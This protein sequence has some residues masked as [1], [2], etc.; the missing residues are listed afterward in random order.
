MSGRF[1]V[2]QWRTFSHL[3]AE[4]LKAAGRADTVMSVTF[5]I[6]PLGQPR[7]PDDLRREIQGLFSSYHA[8][9]LDFIVENVQ[10]GIDALEER[11]GAGEKGKP[12]L[13]I[14]FD[15]EANKFTISD[16]GLGIPDEV[17]KKLGAPSNSD[18]DP[19]RKRG[20]KGVGLVF[21]AWSTLDFRFATKRAEDARIVAGRLEGAFP[22][23]RGN[24]QNY[25]L[26]QEAPD[27]KP[28]FL[29]SEQSGTVFE[30]TLPSSIRVRALLGRLN[31]EGLEALLRTL[32]AAGYVQLPGDDRKNYPKWIQ[33]LELEIAINSANKT[34]TPA[35]FLFPHE[36]FK[37]KA[38]DLSQQL[39][40]AKLEQM[41]GKMKCIYR[42]MNEH[43]VRELFTGEEGDET[44]LE[45][46]EEQ[47]VRAYGAFLDSSRTFKDWSDS[48][49][50]HS[51]GP[52][53]KRQLVQAGL[54]LVTSTMP[55]GEV[56]PIQL[57]YGTG[58]A[59]RA[60]VVVE[61]AN[62]SPDEG[63]KTFQAD[64]VAVAQRIGKKF[65]SDFFVPNR[66][67]LI[68]RSLPHGST[69]GE[70]ATALATAVD[71]AKAKKDLAL[72]S[73]GIVKEPIAEQEVV[74]LFHALLAAK[75]LRGYHVLASHG[76]SEKYDGVFE[77]TLVKE[78]GVLAPKDPL[79]VS[80]ASFGNG[81]R[82]SFPSSIME[83]KAPLSGLIED[84]EEDFK[85]FEEVR[86]AVAWNEG[87][88]RAFEPGSP[89]V[90]EPVDRETPECQFHG[91]TH[92]LRST[93]SGKVIHVILLR[94]V[95]A[96]LTP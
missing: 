50:R 92:I 12:R 28:P 51:A 38:F 47:D 86:L 65:I 7:S 36:K 43:E 35:G 20:H 1:E 17:I 25:P 76:S 93:G 6:D 3:L 15:T 32:T 59:D 63:R 69:E 74:A 24:D 71:S 44:L 48:L 91:E 81:N 19:K 16:N 41:Q 52:G 40:V 45:L 67:L 4:G 96:T 53:R 77:Y 94:D 13:D 10:N 14:S 33:N 83:F 55:C 49:Y 87:D 23:I 80:D 62:V 73:L 75:H 39:S 26:V 56:V 58:N 46:V 95:I 85:Q 21:A 64:V 79:G 2:K 5:P 34:K 88:A 89:Y 57:G 30:F 68:P 66:K 8:A 54:H 37:S 84:F 31:N 72:Q 29:E 60:H 27:F 61:F 90:L 42:M 70:Q 11:F 18:K 22:W 9:D 82:I 78:S